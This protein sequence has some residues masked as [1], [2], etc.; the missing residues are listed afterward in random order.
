MGRVM[1]EAQA[2]SGLPRTETGVPGLDTVLNGGF[3]EGGVYIVQGDPGSGKTILANQ[4]CYRHVER[5]GRVLYVTLLAESHARLLQQ[6]KTLSFFNE[7]AI[8][9]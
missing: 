8:P 2:A 5:G 9:N 6:L 4:V 7:A 1:G 3:V